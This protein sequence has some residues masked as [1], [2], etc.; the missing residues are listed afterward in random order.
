MT[1]A[2]MHFHCPG[3]NPVLVRGTTRG[4]CGQVI[5]LPVVGNGPQRK[6]PACKRIERAHT[7]SHK[8]ETTS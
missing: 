3:C 8:K 1:L 2:D 4:I 5:P 6:C 7:K